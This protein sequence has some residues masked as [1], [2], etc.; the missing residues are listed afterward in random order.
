[1][2]G[3]EASSKR[4]NP[5]VG[6]G[7]STTSGRSWAALELSRGADR[8]SLAS[9]PLLRVQ[10]A[11]LSSLSAAGRPSWVFAGLP[12]TRCQASWPR[13]EP[14]C[15]AAPG[16]WGAAWMVSGATRAASSNA[17]TE[18][19][20]SLLGVPVWRA[21]SVM[22]G[23]SHPR[24]THVSCEVRIVPDERQGQ[25]RVRDRRAAT[26]AGPQVV[27][28]P[29]R[30]IPISGRGRNPIVSGPNASGRG[31]LSPGARTSR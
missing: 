20:S 29:R 14:A 13:A 11:S 30:A 18:R 9:W 17:A 6:V 28:P 7:R 22:P 2:T 21:D 8:R 26:A 27:R 15:S 25:R 5:P 16:A 10:V 24:A 1:M 4:W 23:P 31:A 12:L 3:D 19:L